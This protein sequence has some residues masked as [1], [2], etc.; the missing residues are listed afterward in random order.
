VGK[1]LWTTLAY[2]HPQTTI[3]SNIE[4]AIFKSRIVEGN[5]L[6]AFVFGAATLEE[7][8]YFNAGGYKI[9]DDPASGKVTGDT[10]FWVC[11]M[12]KMIAH[13]SLFYFDYCIYRLCTNLYFTDC[14]P[15][16]NRPRKVNA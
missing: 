7:E 12:T 13:V 3:V 6:P 11:S 8:I 10:V 14:C 4:H 15:P 9:V 5:T 16:V 1:R 2:V